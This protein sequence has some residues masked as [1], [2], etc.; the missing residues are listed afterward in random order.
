MKERE[1]ILLVSVA[2]RVGKQ[3]PCAVL[4]FNP[5]RR[6]AAAPR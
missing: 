3:A 1:K 2:D 5:Y 4:V 6:L